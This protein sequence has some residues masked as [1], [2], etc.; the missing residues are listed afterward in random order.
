[1][2][3]MKKTYS[4]LGLGALAMLGVLCLPST[5]S[6]EDHCHHAPPHHGG[7]DDHGGRG[8]I[9]LGTSFGGDSGYYAD[10]VQTVCVAPAHY[11]RQWVPAQVESFTDSEGR[12]CTRVVREGYSTDVLVPAQYESRVV[13]V[14]VP[15]AEPSV[16]LRFGFRF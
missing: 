7:H 4:M 10:Q 13:R 14:W 12:I 15:A 1:M 6:A 8:G 3:T 9:F 16:G 5:A 2:K 11:E